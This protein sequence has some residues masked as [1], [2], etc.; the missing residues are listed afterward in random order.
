M[1][2]KCF[3]EH[4]GDIKN[5]IEE[6]RKRCVE[7]SPTSN[8]RA[9]SLVYALINKDKT[10]EQILNKEIAF[11]MFFDECNKL[12][13]CSKSEIKS[14]LEKGKIPRYAVET[15]LIYGANLGRSHYPAIIKGYKNNLQSKAKE[16]LKQYVAK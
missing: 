9:S 11:R 8:W 2:L 5:K 13:Y 7:K 16:A 15:A 4:G 14:A 3:I 10:D 6:M 12:D 1:M